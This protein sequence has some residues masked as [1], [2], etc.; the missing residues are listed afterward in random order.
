METHLQKNFA[1]LGADLEQGVEVPTAHFLSKRSEIVRLEFGRLPRP[2]I[3]HLLSQ[4]G[5]LLLPRA[6][7]G[8]GGRLIVG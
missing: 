1:E 5:R 3:D 6:A 8:F 2:R 4:V 7:R